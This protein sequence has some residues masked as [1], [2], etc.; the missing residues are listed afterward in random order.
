MSTGWVTPRVMPTG[1]VQALPTRRWLNY[2]EGYRL[3]KR[4]SMVSRCIEERRS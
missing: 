3:P 1:H 4:A 2:E